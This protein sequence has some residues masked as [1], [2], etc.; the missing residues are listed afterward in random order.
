MAEGKKK[1]VESGKCLEKLQFQW[2]CGWHGVDVSAVSF[3]QQN[4]CSRFSLDP[5]SN[6]ALRSM[7]ATLGEHQHSHRNQWYRMFQDK[8]VFKY[9]KHS[10]FKADQR[11]QSEQAINRYFL[12]LT[13][14]LEIFYVSFCAFFFLLFWENPNSRS[15]TIREE[16]LRFHWKPTA[17]S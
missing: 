16:N 15:L 1:R 6:K 8:H 4:L 2:T 9:F 3:R 17:N 14:S 13:R 5:C 11:Q 10:G 7:C 12:L